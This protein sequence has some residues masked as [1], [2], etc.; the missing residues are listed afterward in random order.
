MSALAT[1]SRLTTNSRQVA[2]LGPEQRLVH[3]RGVPVGRRRGAE[4]LPEALGAAVALKGVAELLEEELQV[5]AHRLLQGGQHLVELDR[6]L[7]L[8]LWNQRAAVELGG[9]WAARLQVD[10]QVALEEEAG[11]ELHGR[12]LADREGGVVELHRH[13]GR[14]LAIAVPVGEVLDL[15]HLAD[16]DAGDPDRALGADVLGVGEDRLQ[17]V[18]VPRDERERLGEG[19]VEAEDDRDDRDQPDPPVGSPLV[20]VR[21]SRHGESQ[22]TLVPSCWRKRSVLPSG[23]VPSCLETF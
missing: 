14:V 12:V 15:G 18:A 9:A 7:G 5:V 21:A 22:K 13:H 1:R 23:A 16:I 11:A 4:R 19:E 8:P 10:E 20:V 17:L 6:D 3:L 2:G